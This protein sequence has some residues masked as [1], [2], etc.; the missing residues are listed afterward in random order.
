[1]LFEGIGQAFEQLVAVIGMVLTL[2]AQRGEPSALAKTV[3]PVATPGSV[4]EQA[5]KV[6]A[7]D[8][9]SRR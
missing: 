2:G 8:V 5:V 9:A 3:Q 7:D 6:G 4:V 1:M